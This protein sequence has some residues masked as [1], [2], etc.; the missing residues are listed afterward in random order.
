M[1]EDTEVLMLSD[2]DRA[3]IHRIM[4]GSGDWFSAQLL[5]FI[6][7][8]APDRKNLE[9]LRSAFPDH[10]EAVRWW[11]DHSSEEGPYPG[12]LNLKGKL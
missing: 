10:V 4:E 8:S 7:D 1:V 9:R 2:Y 3:N 11:W 6:R 5:R 12:Y